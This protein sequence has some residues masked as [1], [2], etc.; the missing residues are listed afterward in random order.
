MM[1]D[2]SG[3]IVLMLAGDARRKLASNNRADGSPD[4][5]KAEVQGSNAFYGTYSVSAKEH[6]IAIHIEACS[7]ANWDGTDQTRP[8]SL[9][10]DRLTWQVAAA[11]GGGSAE[12]VW[13]RAK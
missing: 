4:E 10:G 12:L 7:F 2:H 9:S 3:H 6:A 8:F 13:K 5:N 11:S 1:L